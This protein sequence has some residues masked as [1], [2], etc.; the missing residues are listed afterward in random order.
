MKATGLLFA[1]CLIAV[2][3]SALKVALSTGRI[4]QGGACLI[5]RQNTQ[6]GQI[7]PGQTFP[8]TPDHCQQTSGPSSKTRKGITEKHWTLKDSRTDRA[9]PFPEKS[10]RSGLNSSAFLMDYTSRTGHSLLTTKMESHLDY[11]F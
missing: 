9:S 2:I 1:M 6:R 4:Y 7:A 11:H 3:K 5:P 8:T 10:Q